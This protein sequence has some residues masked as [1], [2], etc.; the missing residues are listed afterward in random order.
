MFNGSWLPQ[1]GLHSFVFVWF[2]SF[3][4]L[5]FSLFCC[6]IFLCFVCFNFRFL[7]F[8]ERENMMLGGSGSV[9]D[10]GWCCSRKKNMTEILYENII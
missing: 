9:E 8:R 4:G 6:G 7:I 3:V 5:M 10:L 1:N 2:L